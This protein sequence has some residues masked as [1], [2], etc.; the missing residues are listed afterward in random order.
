MSSTTSRSTVLALSLAGA[1]IGLGCQNT[2]RGLEKDA[3]KNGATL[4]SETKEMKEDVK[5]GAEKAAEAVGDAADAIGLQAAAAKATFDVKTALMADKTVDASRIDVDS[6]AKARVVHLRGK[7]AT[8][9][10]VDAATLIGKNNAA[11]WTISNELVIA[12]KGA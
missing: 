9:A 12:P 4:Q 1:L 3:E 5:E 7:V 10:E 11:G 6:D 8:Q 2:T